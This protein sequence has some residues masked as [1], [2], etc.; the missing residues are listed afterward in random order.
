MR[1]I[2][3]R[4]AN[5]NNLKNIDLAIPRNKVVCFVGVSGSGKSTIAFD[6]IAREGERQYFESLNAYARRYLHKSNRPKVDS[7]QGISSTIVINQDR[8]HGNPRSTVGTLTEAYTYLRLLYARVGMPT[9]GSSHFS[10]N[11]PDGACP[12]CKGLGTAIEP[13]P[14]KL[15]DYDR[16]LNEGALLH[17]NWKVDTRMWNIIKRRTILTWTRSFATSLR[18]R[19]RCCSTLRVNCMPTARTMVPTA[20]HSRE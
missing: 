3:I 19:C 17:S 8:V 20:G 7:L 11:H 18:K 16:S 14:G 12:R 2:S 9:M 6:I 10:F 4:G 5:V 13:D 15:V 1:D